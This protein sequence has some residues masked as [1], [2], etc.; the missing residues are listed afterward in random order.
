M[1]T[2]LT[3]NHI[4]FQYDSKLELIKE[5]DNLELT[6]S[7]QNTKIFMVTLNDDWIIYFS[8]NPIAENNRW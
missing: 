3:T 1:S 2:I 4:T 7:L 6:S 8:Q 5:N